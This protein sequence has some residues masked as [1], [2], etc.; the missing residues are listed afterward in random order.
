MTKGF[1]QFLQS[2]KKAEI[3]IYG[4]IC[5]WAW[6]EFGEASG[7]TVVDKINE[8]DADEIDVH[9]D[10]YGGEVSEGWAIYNALRNCKAKVTTYADGF[11]A[12]AAVYPFLAGDVRIAN[13]VSAFY[14]HEV[15]TGGY[16]YADDLKKAAEEAEKMTEIGINAFVERA[17]MKRETVEELMKAETWI[18]AEEA[19]GY[20]IATEIKTGTDEGTVQSARSAIIEKLMQKAEAPKEETPEEEPK[21]EQKEEQKPEEPKPEEPEEHKE[22]QKNKNIFAAIA[23]AFEL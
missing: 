22:K 19:I 8:A 21:P 3:Y 2:G 18:S 9:I 11:V 14:L 15:M 4:D 12:S 7:K 1:C 23:A 20:G 13:S 17:G 5:T 6:E 16:G 10:S